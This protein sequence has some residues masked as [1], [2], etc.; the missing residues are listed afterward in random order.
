MGSVTIDVYVCNFTTDNTA[1]AKRLFEELERSLK[2]E[3]THFQAIQR[4]GA[5]G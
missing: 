1:K 3:R 5:S 2:P 4:G